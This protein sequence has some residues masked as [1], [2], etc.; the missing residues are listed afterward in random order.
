MLRYMN[1]REL[2]IAGIKSLRMVHFYQI[3]KDN[4]SIPA[5]MA[6]YDKD[7]L[8]NLCVLDE[9]YERLLDKI[10]DVYDE[11]KDSNGLL[12]ADPYS[13][14]ILDR[15]YN[16][17]IGKYQNITEGASEVSSPLYEH[18]GYMGDTVVPVI[19]YIIDELYGMT[20]QKLVWNPLA[21]DWFGTGELSAI[22][23][24]RRI[25]FP[26]KI[27]CVREGLYQIYVG[28]VLTTGN[29]M[30]LV[31]KY[32]EKGI[33][34][35][36]KSS[37]YKIEGSI[38]YLVVEDQLRCIADVKIDGK[39]AYISN[40]SCQ[41]ENCKI[42]EKMMNRLDRIMP[43]KVAWTLPW[44]AVLLFDKNVKE[45]NGFKEAECIVAVVSNADKNEHLYC[46]SYKELWSDKYV[47]YTIGDYALDM[48]IDNRED[49]H[50]QIH[51]CD[52]GYEARGFYKSK[53]ANRF[54]SIN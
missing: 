48:I 37:Q 10:L 45:E 22:N 31:I 49:G 42:S 15:A 23:G 21:K 46:L 35:E 18:K 47:T 53:L 4:E 8:I 3:N 38:N 19:K 40:D 7:K 12:V 50:T 20:G 54:F 11:E 32:G 27:T 33:E 34:I 51:F 16:Q 5:V 25:H 26:Y 44:G 24:E 39:Q 9:D 1:N 17:D 43:S 13:K 30:S 2:A 41:K 29:R 28:N 14:F 6:Y 52:M 36:L